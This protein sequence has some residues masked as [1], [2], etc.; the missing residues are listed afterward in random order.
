[1][2]R[3]V[4]KDLP[5]RN[6]SRFFLAPNHNRAFS[7]INVISCKPLVWLHL[8]FHRVVLQLFLMTWFNYGKNP[9]KTKLLMEPILYFLGHFLSTDLKLSD[10]DAFNVYLSIQK[11]LLEITSTFSS[12]LLH[13]AP[14]QHIYYL[15]CYAYGILIY[16]RLIMWNNC[17]LT[18]SLFRITSR[19]C[20]ARHNCAIVTK[21]YCSNPM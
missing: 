6:S 11:H 18:C 2:C 3:P 12:D 15:L 9:L 21:H 10:G 17:I 5:L 19:F 20:G 4:I 7:I 16:R 8:N 14:T 1:M 13:A